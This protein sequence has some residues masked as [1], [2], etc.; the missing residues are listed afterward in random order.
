MC[1]GQATV[2]ASAVVRGSCLQPAQFLDRLSRL[3]LR[4]LHGRLPGHLRRL[5]LCLHGLRNR[6]LNGLRDGRLHLRLVCRLVLRQRLEPRRIRGLQ[7][8]ARLLEACGHLGRLSLRLL[9]LL[10]RRSARFTEISLERPQC[11]RVA[12]RLLL[13]SL[14]FGA[15]LVQLLDSCLHLLGG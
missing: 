15:Q 10:G 13:R 2:A 5:P 1:G 14:R 4:R 3:E 8:R 7:L 9:L 11:V 12:R 6:L